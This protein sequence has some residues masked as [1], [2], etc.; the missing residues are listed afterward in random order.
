M[1]PPGY[2][3]GVPAP[4]MAGQGQG[5]GVP[6]PGMVAQGMPVQGMPMQTQG[7][8]VEQML[9]ACPGILMQQK[10]DIQ[11]LFVPCQKR[12]RYKITSDGGWDSTNCNDWEQSPYKKNPQIFKA[13]EEGDFCQRVCCFNRRGFQMFIRPSDKGDGQH[14]YQLDRPFRCSIFC[15]C[16]LFNP[17]EL[18][19]K[20]HNDKPIGR[21]VQ[22]FRC[23]ETALC[24]TYF[25]KVEDDAGATQYY[26]KDKL[27]CS[28]NMCAPSFCCGQH[29][30]EILD[31]QEQPTDGYLRNIFPG[32]NFKG[33]VGGAGMRDSY[34][35]K[36]PTKANAQQKALLFG[37]LF[38]IE[39]MLFEASG[40]D[41]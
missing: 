20:D 31:A 5:Y 35:L 7:P 14:A 29:N 17:Q 16:M 13:K 2:D 12:N 28:T 22:D 15:C 3:Q 1:P 19:V 10:F 8:A 26:Y 6:A 40:N 11:E 34:H 24:C 37:G 32:C 25:W 38:L 23:V 27:Y 21:V 36:F 39:Y 9:D 33:M 4:G 41:E 18:T 30:I